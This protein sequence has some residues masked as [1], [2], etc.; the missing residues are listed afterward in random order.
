MRF[1]QRLPYGVAVF[2][3]VPE[4]HTV[5]LLLFVRVSGYKHFFHGGGVVAG[6]VH[7]GGESHGSGGEVLNLFQTIAQPFHGY[8][9]LRHVAQ[10]AGRVRRN[11]I[12]YQLLVESVLA[13]DVVET[14][15]DVAETVEGLVF[16]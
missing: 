7:L 6:V 11:E 14:P 5:L 15:F 13:A 4:K 9:K 8:G 3:L 16:G 12:R 2:G 10:G 1:Q